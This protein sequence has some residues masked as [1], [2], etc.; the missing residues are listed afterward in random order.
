MVLGK[1]SVLQMA[2]YRTNKLAI[3]SHCVDLRRRRW[4]V[5]ADSSLRRMF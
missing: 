4:R 2:K 3:W 5:N 1:Y